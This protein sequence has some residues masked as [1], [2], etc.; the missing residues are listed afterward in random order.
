MVPPTSKPKDPL[1]CIKLFDVNLPSIAD[2]VLLY[3][4]LERQSYLAPEVS[5]NQT[6]HL[7]RYL[8]MA[9]N[10]TKHEIALEF[11][12]TDP[13]LSTLSIYQQLLRPL[14][15]TWLLVSKYVDQQ[16]YFF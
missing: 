5:G 8:E 13:Q 4:I 3:H 15:E 14:S 11:Y 7:F 9:L 1:F 6:A 2:R 10:R 12:S 16:G